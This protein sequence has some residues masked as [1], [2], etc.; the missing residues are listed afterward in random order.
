MKWNKNK[1]KSWLECN[2]IIIIPII[3]LV[4][5]AVIGVIIGLAGQHYGFLY[6]V[7]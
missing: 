5:S 1:F 7:R 2:D 3:V 4:I 6:Y